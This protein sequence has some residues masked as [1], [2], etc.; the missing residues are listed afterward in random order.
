MPNAVSPS[1]S[2]LTTW[3]KP[4][5]ASILYLGFARYNTIL[6]AELVEPPDDPDKVNTLTV[7]FVAGDYTD[8]RP[9]MTL[10][11]GTTPG[12]YQLGR[13]YIRKAPDASHIFIGEY[14]SVDWNSHLPEE[15]Y[16]TVVDDFNLWARPVNNDTST[17]KLD[18]DVVYTNQFSQPDPVVNMGSHYAKYLKDDTDTLVI[19]PS[20]NG[21]WVPVTGTITAYLW[22]APGCSASTGMTTVSPTITFDTDGTYPIYCTVTTSTGKTFTGVR[23]AL[24]FNDT[25]PPFRVFDL[26]E[27]TGSWDDGGY[28]FS[29]EC[30]DTMD[31]TAIRDLS[32]TILFSR[33]FCDGEEITASTQVPTSVGVKAVGWMSDESIRLNPEYGTVSFTVYGASYVLASILS[34]T[35]S[36]AATSGSGASWSKM[37]TMTV[38]KFVWYVAHFRSTITRIMDVYLTG[39]TR[40]TGNADTMEDSLWNQ[41][42]EITDT[43]IFARPVI[44]EFGRMFLQIDPQLVPVESR[45][46]SDVI[47]L[48]DSSRQ[49]GMEWDMVVETSISKFS[50]SAM[51][52]TADTRSRTLY[53]LSPG[54]I[55]FR[56]GSTEV[57]DKFLAATQQQANEMA[58]LYVGFRNNPIPRIEISIKAANHLIGLFPYQAFHLTVDPTVDPR[59]RSFDG[60]LIPRSVT[61][62]WS[63]ET[64][65]WDMTYVCE[66]ESF[67]APSCNGDI[68]GHEG[69]DFSDTPT[70]PDPPLPPDDLGPLDLPPVMVGLENDM[71]LIY[72]LN[73]DEPEDSEKEVEWFGFNGGFPDDSYKHDITDVLTTRSGKVYAVYTGESSGVHNELWVA[74]SVGGTFR[75]IIN[76]A[77]VKDAV[78][79]GAG[80]SAKLIG[81]GRNRLAD[82]Q[83]MLA[84]SRTQDGWPLTDEVTVFIGND[85]GFSAG[86]TITDMNSMPSYIS[87]GNGIWLITGGIRGIFADVAAWKFDS[88]GSQIGTKVEYNDS[89]S[90]QPGHVRAGSSSILYATSWDR[91][92]RSPDNGD[93][94]ATTAGGTSIGWPY[95]VTWWFD[96]E[97]SSAKMIISPT[98]TGMFKSSDYG[99]SWSSL[100]GVLPLGT[101]AVR[102]LDGSPDKFAL[103]G[104]DIYATVDFCSNYILRTGNL[105]DLE[106]TP[107]IRA[108]WTV[109]T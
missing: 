104:A 40:Y 100:N 109:P 59:G 94:F 13:A 80:Y 88:S 99:G 67:P 18:A 75:Q 20:A 5:H 72:T 92:Y 33:D 107:A 16:L 69:D 42:K 81:V 3:Q 70:P 8:V 14:S 48:T 2:D 63:S 54:H 25:N 98:G 31:S 55:G 96:V 45:D 19:H 103:A 28:K 76:D 4:G 21:S 30:W 106:P 38:D 44:D 39:D 58:G 97:P 82:N 68:P 24:V 57:A 6:T 102:W 23:Y 35:C 32:F 108:L 46:W 65:V 43:T 101:R 83:L 12:G 27:L 9:G 84:I 11:I 52:V 77:W 64:G 17:P 37:P 36:L 71:G 56:Q 86:D 47:D 85:S 15:M 26:G 61:K 90:P 10:Y 34:S 91:F 78:G 66:A 22:E 49:D 50:S 73:F 41:I 53:S 51:A 7:N 60:R 79:A 89:L 29:V 95:P 105:R 62:R 87:F 74:N 93:T 1:P